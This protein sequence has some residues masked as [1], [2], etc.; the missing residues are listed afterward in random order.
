MARAD[1]YTL[2]PLDHYARLMAIHP[3]AFNQCV[4]P[5]SPYP[6]ACERVWIQYG[7]MDYDT[8]RLVGREELAQAIYTAE[9]MIAYACGFWPAPR[10]TSAEKHNW[11]RPARGAQVAYP[12]ID[13][14][15]GYV[16]EGGQRALTM[17]DEDAPIVYSDEDGDGVLDTATISITAAQM[18]AAS[19]SR[20]E[21][22]VFFANQTDDAWWIPFVSITE[23]AATGDITIVGRRSQFVDP[24]LW[25]VSDDIS[26]TVNA[27]FV[28][29]VD[30]YRRYNDPSQPAQVVWKG[31]TDAC[32][33]TLCADTCQTSCL[34]V[35]DER[36]GI[37]RTIP[38]TYSAGSWSASSFSIGRLPDKSR[39]WYRHGLDLV[40]L[41]SM[42]QIKPTLAEAIARLANTYL[43]SEPCGCD[44]TRHRWQR[45]R[46]EQDIDSY[47]A[48][49][50]MSAFGSTMKG[51]IFAW[52]VIKRPAPLATG[53]A[54]T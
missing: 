16:I 11:P 15:W 8:G 27:N 9:E 33:T 47:D 5:D 42:L 1:T 3:D 4:N 6:G 14:D 10:W 32:S 39:L 35:S 29:V 17:I 2:L 48:A 34:S 37:V 50:A 21:V 19:A 52:S 22:A 40:D 18:T 23:D 36:N 30:V 24:D 7:W 26:L 12:P 49:L 31:G 53:G 43:I 54:L 25:E 38:G 28:T 41:R 51:A 20:A 13:A 46:Q 44:Q 45:D